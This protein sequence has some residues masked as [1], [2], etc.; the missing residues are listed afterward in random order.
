MLN[1]R[2]SAEMPTALTA[3]TVTDLLKR[4]GEPDDRGLRR[5]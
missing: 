2:I 4:P 1:A 5:V 3:D